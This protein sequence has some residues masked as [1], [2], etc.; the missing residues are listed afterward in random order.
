MGT[1]TVVLTANNGIT[2][3]ATHTFTLT[4][5]AQQGGDNNG[6]DTSGDT[7]TPTPT[8]TTR[9]V[10]INGVS[11]NF[12]ISQGVATLNLPTNTVNQLISAAQNNAA[13]NNTIIF[14]LS[15]INGVTIFRTKAVITSHQ[16]F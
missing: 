8:T 16:P 9:T 4:V 2:P 7:W 3:N 6:G 1:Y 14:N 12:S 11:V 15:N 5:V 13:L 10:T